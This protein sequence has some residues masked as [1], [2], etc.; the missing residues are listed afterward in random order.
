MQDKER[1]KKQFKDFTFDEFLLI[2]EKHHHVKAENKALKKKVADYEKIL[3]KSKSFMNDLINSN[4]YQTIL[5]AVKNSTNYVSF[6]LKVGGSMS[7][8]IDELASLKIAEKIAELASTSVE[9]APHLYS[10]NERKLLTTIDVTEN[11]N[12]QK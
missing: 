10:E 8:I 9:L 12:T 6:F 11:T 4:F 5:N 3:I 1:L 2:M 7:T